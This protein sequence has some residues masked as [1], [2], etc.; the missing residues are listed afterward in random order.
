MVTGA[1]TTSRFYAALAAGDADTARRLI[2]D[3]VE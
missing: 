1:E 3:D 2:S